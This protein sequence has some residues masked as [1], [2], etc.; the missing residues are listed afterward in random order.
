VVTEFR[1]PCKVIVTLSG[2]RQCFSLE[3]QLADLDVFREPPPIL[4]QGPV[5]T[6]GNAFQHART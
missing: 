4:I 2:A 6:I 5:L 3:L 1:K